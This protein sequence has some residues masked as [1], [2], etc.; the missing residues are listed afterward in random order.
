MHAPLEEQLSALVESHVV[1]DAPAA[2]HAFSESTVHCP[3][4]LQHPL[5]HDVASQTQ[6]P[7]VQCS[8]AAHAPPVPQRQAP[9][10]AQL[11]LRPVVHAT[12]V[13]P[14]V[15]QV[16]RL[17]VRHVAPSQQ[18]SAQDA[19]SQT[20]RPATQLWP[21][22]HAACPPHVHAPAVHPSDERV[23]QA[24]QA[25]PAVPQ[26]VMDMALHVVPLQH[27]P[28]HTQPLHTPAVHVSP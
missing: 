14:P 11:S 23:S 15:P 5:G 6:L 21:A 24:L 18:P 17:R 3:V 20:Q 1:Q 9:S 27:P 7:E 16:P 26:E 10:A 25:A 4:E 28:G 2:P 12:H 8:P 19:A 13:E 22:A